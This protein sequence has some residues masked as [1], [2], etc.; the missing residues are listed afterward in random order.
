MNTQTK[1][2][3]EQRK[4]LMARVAKSQDG[5]SNHWPDVQ[6]T[7]TGQA[8]KRARLSMWDEDHLSKF[9]AHQIEQADDPWDVHNACKYAISEL[10]RAAFAAGKYGDELEPEGP[11]NE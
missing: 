6:I 7:E 1:L 3:E 4:T 9:L 5:G 8:K 11:A 2:T 10:E